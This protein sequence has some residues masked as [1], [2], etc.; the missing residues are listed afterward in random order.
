MECSDHDFVLVDRNDAPDFDPSELQA[1][2]REDLQSIRNWLK[3]SEYA[4]DSSEFKRHLRP[5]TS[6]T[7]TWMREPQYQDWADSPNS[8]LLWIKANPGVG[9]S[10]AAA[11]VI[12]EYMEVETSPVLYF[13]FR[14]IIASNRQPWDLIRD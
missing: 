2:C 12:S 11:H 5:Y 14:Q 7:D 6:G 3:P 9:K 13:F 1:L 10:V 8:S 4:A